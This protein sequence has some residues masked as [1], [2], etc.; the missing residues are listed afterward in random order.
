[1]IL[2]WNNI[3]FINDFSL[4]QC[5]SDGGGNLCPESHPYA[6]LS[7][8]NYCC[9]EREKGCNGNRLKCPNGNKCEDCKSTL[10]RYHILIAFAFLPK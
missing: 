3:I 1:M 4:Y 6:D 7:N 5:I 10:F 9:Q 8:E 2:H